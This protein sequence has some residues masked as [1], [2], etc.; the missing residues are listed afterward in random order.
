METLAE[1][2]L[3]LALDDDNG[4]VSWQR[5]NALQYGLGGALLMDLALL[6]RIDSVDGQIVPVDQSPTGD[7]ALDTALETIRASASSHDPKHWVKKLGSQKGIQEHLA[8]RL[9]ARGILRDQEHT[10]LWVFHERHYP[11]SD[12]GPE[13]AVRRQLRD[14]VLTG[15][16]PDARS[17]LMLSLVN[18]CNL[19]DSVFS[20]DERK[21][22]KRRIKELVEGE[23]FGTAVGRAVAEVTAAVAAA[24]SSATFTTVVASGSSH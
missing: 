19:T 16:E 20:R 22:T 11:T 15:A 10:F 13:S 8:R 7:E 21:Q 3:L 1:D 18:A 17:V 9:V 2:L 14:V 4:T 24:I 12:P 5:A 6:E 23:Q